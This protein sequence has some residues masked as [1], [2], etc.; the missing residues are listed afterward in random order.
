VGEQHSGKPGKPF[1]VKVYIQGFFASQE[2]SANFKTQNQVGITRIRKPA[3]H[4]E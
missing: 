1:I 2:E 3:D 4:F